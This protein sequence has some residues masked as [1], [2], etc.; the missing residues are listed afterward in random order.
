MR[1]GNVDDEMKKDLKGQVQAPF[2]PVVRKAIVAS[3]EEMNVNPRARS[4]RLRV[5]ERTTWM[6]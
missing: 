6:P 5:A 4:A 3:E 2:R 1:S